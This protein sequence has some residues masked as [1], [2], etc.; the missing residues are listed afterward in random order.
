MWLLSL[1]YLGFFR[2][3]VMWEDWTTYM[4]SYSRS[5]AIRS[6]FVAA[7]VRA[8]VLNLDYCSGMW[9]YLYV[10]ACTHMKLCVLSEQYWSIMQT[11]KSNIGSCENSTHC[12]S[13]Y[14]I[15]AISWAHE[16]CSHHPTIS[17]AECTQ[18]D[19]VVSST[20]LSSFFCSTKCE[21]HN[22]LSLSPTCCHLSYS[23][24]VW[25]AALLCTM[26]HVLS[27]QERQPVTRSILW[28]IHF[29]F[30]NVRATTNV[31]I[32][33]THCRHCHLLSSVGMWGW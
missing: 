25:G 2:N 10:H 5:D 7:Y 13:T 30:S 31:Q 9:A 19:L 24:C 6:W 21:D 27:V 28:T 3:R 11:F 16:G 33:C 23:K 26:L 1:D 12:S 22:R 29:A 8:L 18:L 15:W 32:H 4:V 20:F 17:I 14:P